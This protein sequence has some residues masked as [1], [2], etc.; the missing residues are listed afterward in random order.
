MKKILPSLF[1]LLVGL[2]WTASAKAV[3]CSA[4]A[5]PA[6]LQN[7]ST[8]DFTLTINNTGSDAIVWVQVIVS[9]TSVIGLNSVTG[10]GWSYADEVLTGGSIAGGG[11]GSFNLNLTGLANGSSNVSTEV[12]DGVEGNNHSA[13][14]TGNIEVSESV[15]VAP[16]ISSINLTVGNS[17]A[18]LTWNTDV[19]ATGSV[20]YGTS[21]GY[22]SSTTTASG[23][24]HSA[25]MSGLSASTTYHYQI[26]VTGEGGSRSTADATFTTSAASVTTTTTT[27]VTNTVTNTATVTK[28]ITDTTPPVVKVDSLQ[29]TANGVQ[30]EAVYET[31]PLIT[32][33]VSDDRGVAKVEF[34]IK[35]REESWSTASLEGSVG[36]KKMD[37]EFVPPVSLDGTYTIEVRGVDVFG[38]VSVPKVTEF[39]IDQLLPTV[40]GGVIS[41]GAL[42]LYAEGGVV[43]VLAGREYEVVLYEAGGADTVQ[44]S[45]YNSQFTMQKM[46]TG[47]LWRGIVDFRSQMLDSS[48]EIVQSIVKAVDGAGNETEREWVK[49][50]VMDAPNQAGELYYLD[51]TTK[52]FGLWEAAEYG[53]KQG[54][55]GWYAPQGEYFVQDGKVISQRIVMEADGWI[56]GEWK[57]GEAKWWEKLLGLRRQVQLDLL[58]STEGT[59][60]A[61]SLLVGRER[62][63]G[64]KSVVYLGTVDLPW[65]GESL[66]RAQ[67]WAAREGAQ[68]VELALQG[69][70]DPKGEWLEKLNVGLLPQVYLVNDRGDTVD[71]KEG[72]W[73][74]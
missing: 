30:Q 24:S 57:I 21:S 1:L 54:V 7:G 64:K 11:S 2:W 23:T 59:E 15:A 62:W 32:G 20:S 19:A 25:T 35:N 47:G 55:L 37:W 3:E 39:V 16:Q 26:T 72:I 45:I 13:C 14:S 69:A 73:E 29:R 58:S 74:R 40:G 6:T 67:E 10:A 49:F 70:D 63:I 61:R 43:T 65:Y 31:A 17:S 66:R 56:A 52:R 46:G 12:G 36:A 41:Y 48:G 8:A 53:Q 5:S 60:P 22:G 68:V 27:T 42:P 28:I 51:P 38:N 9:D 34:R 50:R 4:S 71:Y 33:S 44:L 18:T